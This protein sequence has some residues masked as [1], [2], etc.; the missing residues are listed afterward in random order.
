[1]PSVETSDTCLTSIGLLKQLDGTGSKNLGTG[2]VYQKLCSSKRGTNRDTF[3][4]SQ[5]RSSWLYLL[6]NLY[7]RP[8]ISF[9]IFVGSPR[10]RSSRPYSRTLSSMPSNLALTSSTNYSYVPAGYNSSSFSSS[11][12][13]AGNWAGALVSSAAC[14][15]DWGNWVLGGLASTMWIW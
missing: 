6:R 8:H 7:N 12:F 3:L 13:Y 15:L 14:E 4:S 5:L 1:M 10:W 2:W 11:V 9:Y